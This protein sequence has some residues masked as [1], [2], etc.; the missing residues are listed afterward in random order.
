MWLMFAM[1]APLDRQDECD[2]AMDHVLGSMTLR[3][4]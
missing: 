4:D 3:T 1:S 2:A